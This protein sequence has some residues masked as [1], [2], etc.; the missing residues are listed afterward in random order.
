MRHRI[1][2]CLVGKD[3]RYDSYRTKSPKG[4]WSSWFPWY[5]TA[6]LYGQLGSCWDELHPGP[7]WHAGGP[8]DIRKLS[9]IDNRVYRYKCKAGKPTLNPCEVEYLMRCNVNPRSYFNISSI[10]VED[11]TAFLVANH[12]VN[13]SS[14]G[15]TG[16]AKARPGR[17]GADLAQFIAEFR[18]VPR[19]LKATANFFHDSWKAA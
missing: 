9:A 8:C 14:Y 11:P 10:H 16:W 3:K 1:S 19:T 6:D 17:P 7:P 5:P 4:S 18:D 2:G 13:S 12:F 15:A